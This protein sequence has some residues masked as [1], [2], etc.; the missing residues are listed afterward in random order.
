ML[1]LFAAEGFAQIQNYPNPQQNRS[2]FEDTTQRNRTD[3]PAE[4]EEDLD[5]LRA[6]AE[7]SKD[8]IIFTSKFIRYTNI[9]LL[10]DSTQTLPLDTT[11]ADFENYNV[12]NQRL[13]PTIGV[14]N[15][16]LA[17]RDLLF[18]PPKTIGFDVGL[19]SFD[20]YIV[21]P[22]EVQYYRARSPFTRLYYVNGGQPE[23][24][25]KVIHSQNIK[26]NWN[27]GA[28]Y[29]RM[30]NQ[31][32]YARQVANHLNAAIFS[33][34]ESPNKRYNAL[35][36]LFFNNIRAQESGSI[37]NDSIFVQQTASLSKTDEPVR[38][39]AANNASNNWRDN[40]IYFKQFYYIG[41]ID[42][43]N[44]DSGTTS[45][46]ILPTQRI[47]HTLLY[48]QRQY[49]YSQNT[50]DG[51]NVFANTYGDPDMSRDSFRMVN[52][53]NEFTYSFYLRARTVRFVKNEMKVDL[54][55]QHDYYRYQQ[56]TQDT[57][58]TAPGVVNKVRRNEYNN[59]F[60]NIT[61]KARAGYRFSDRVTLGADLQQ[62]AQG[63]NFGDYLYQANANILIGNKLGRI[64]MEAYTQSNRPALLFERWAWSHY[65][66]DNNFEKQKVTSL[67]FAYQNT[68]FRFQVKAEYFLVNNYLY[69]TTTDSLPNNPVPAQAA[70]V[71]MIKLSLQKDFTF[72]KR[73]HWD[74]YGA[75]QLTDNRDLLRTPEVY[76][77]TSLYFSPPKLFNVLTI[78]AGSHVRFNTSHL[79]PSYA[80]GIGQF[81]NGRDVTFST[82]PIADVFLKANLKRVNLLLRYDYINQNLFQKGYYTVNRYPM[83]DGLFKFGV[84]WNFYD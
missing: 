35:G 32:F 10:N 20:Y 41:R 8:S 26:P 27:I 33:W 83:A 67:S 63:Y 47:S 64:V 22:E 76:A 73:I 57:L 79:A 18:S 55:L 30:T 49:K 17:A 19:H 61:L 14:G 15:L 28:Q 25:F 74:N 16:G 3:Q 29:F 43:I 65:R 6:K 45:K 9:Q 80:P 48:N 24:V 70:S 84:S 59:N 40:G 46:K 75:Y 72:F 7:G 23:Q 71:N 12:L 53:R 66:W 31:G 1:M 78:E 60:Q 77:T 68:A 44:N 50:A 36:N 11:L 21:R 34:Y 56:F 62:V 42:S 82:Y 51:F 38:L 37:V 54:A 2:P 5:S 81:Y 13:R 69:F 39:T 52:I 58:T 4:A